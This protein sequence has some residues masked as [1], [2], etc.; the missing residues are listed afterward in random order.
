MVK[1]SEPEPALSFHRSINKL[2]DPLFQTDLLHIVSYAAVFL[3]LI[4]DHRLVS[5][6][7]CIK[8][9][10][11]KREFHTTFSHYQQYYSLIT[12][13]HLTCISVPSTKSVHSVFWNFYDA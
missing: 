1:H 6:V 10:Q 9:T 5:L 13:S 4:L 3:S 8:H 7:I 12:Q 11:T 2:F